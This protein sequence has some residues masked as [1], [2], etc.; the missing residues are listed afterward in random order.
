[1]PSLVVR[2][3]RIVPGPLPPPP[4]PAAPAAVRESAP[5]GPS[6]FARLL[7]GVGGEL[8]RGEALVR[9]AA[10]GP[11]AGAMGAAELIA[12]QAGVYRYAETVDLAAKLVDHAT[13]SVRTVLQGP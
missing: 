1:M 5:S 3:P 7:A 13:S 9:G 2:E 11:G 8:A 6:P 10:G 4:S 12:L